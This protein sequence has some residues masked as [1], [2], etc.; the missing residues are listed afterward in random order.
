MVLGQIIYGACS[1]A[2][3]ALIALMLL[4]GRLSGQGIVIVA[5]S[6]L[7]AFWA[8]DLAI[9][10]LFPHGASAGLD[11]LRLSAWLIM[12]VG[13]VAL[14]QG[15]RRSSAFLAFLLAV[16][17]SAVVVGWNLG[18]VINDGGTATDGRLSDV[19]HVGL[20]VGGLLAIENLLRNIEDDRRRNFWPLCLALGATFAFDLFVYAD[21]LMVPG[22]G[23][24]LTEGRGLVGLFAVPLLALAIVRNREWR[25][26]IHVS[27][28]VVLHTA[29]LLVT[30]AFFLALSAIGVVVRELGGGWGPA[31]QIL[32]LL[33]SAIVLVPVLGAREL[34][35]H[36]KE[37][38]SKNFFSHRYDYR[39]EWLRFVET[40][41]EPGASNDKLSVRVIK[42][43]AQ[44]IDS[45]GG[46]LW[47]INDK[48]NYSPEAG[49]NSWVHSQQKISIH[50]PF[51]SGF[52]HGER[53]QV[54][55]TPVETGATDFH[56]TGVAVPLL[57]NKRIIAFAML[58]SANRNYSFDRETF[59]LLR[60]AGKQAASYL[61]EEQS[62][63][64]L[65]DSRLLTEFSKRFAFVVHDI[66]NLAAQL[67]LT[68]T[69]ARSHLNNPEFRE[70]MLRTLEDSVAKMNRLIGELQGRGVHDSPRGIT[71][72]TVIAKLARELAGFGTQVETRL[73]APD[74]TVAMDG[75]DLRSVLDHLINNAREA[76]AAG[77]R[78]Q[79]VV[80]ASR[81]VGDKVTI[82]VSD[83]G[84]GMDDEFVRN[85]LFRPFRST[86]SGGLGIGAYQT[87]ELLRN[88]GGDL[89][90]ISQKGVGTI[91]RMTLP[92]QDQRRSAA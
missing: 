70:D 49:W 68:L 51:I 55:H 2:F 72:D 84:P 19:L 77:G 33:G 6:G 91:M 89:D 78:S 37:F 75:D 31:L 23:P 71:P 26:D 83:S 38:I 92:I 61:A 60:A 42:A 54:Q 46:I 36:L 59:D 82:E 39:A 30:G 90:V 86:K 45:P 80:V 73:S 41:S 4:R 22:S 29:T 47:R 76:S 8:A 64:A 43:L 5:A 1:I 85:E 58:S 12:L 69:N 87:R 50:D 27:H 16:A 7:S 56:G 25:I 3:V 62:E 66:K 9:P 20:T 52:R 32:M 34:R 35:I 14:R 81:T 18:V 65:I 21:R 53:I 40:V 28:S 44:I 57:Y 15:R 63:R 48:D 17:F 67:G 24:S 79:P 10:G 88:S 74:C 11:S 13:L